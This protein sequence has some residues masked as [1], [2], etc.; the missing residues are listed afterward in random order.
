[1]RKRRTR[2]KNIREAEFMRKRRTILK[3][4]REA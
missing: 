2:L 4:R 3:N 1:M